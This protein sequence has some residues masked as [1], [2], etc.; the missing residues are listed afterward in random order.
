[1]PTTPAAAPAPGASTIASV[2]NPPAPASETN[3]GSYVL[4]DKHKLSPGDR[5]SFEIKED[6]TNAIPLMVT[7]FAEL[8][9]PYIGR[10]SVG[11]K[12]CKQ[13]AEEL[14]VALEKDYYYRATVIIGLD[15]LSPVLGK[16]YIFGPVKAPGAV[17]IPANE[18]FT[19]G[20]AIMKVGGFGD[21]ANPKKVQVI[22]KTPDGNRTFTVNLVNVLK[23]GMTDED[24][25]LEPDDFIIVPESNI[26][27][28][29]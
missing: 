12:T 27:F 17:D 14:K 21:F 20:K 11:G 26:N 16:V 7:E 13:L 15:A 19:V 4:D 23:K 28:G 22:R 1:V 25:A 6:R 24:I 29:W 9:V 5:I 18:R 8:E 3:A 10:V 2:T